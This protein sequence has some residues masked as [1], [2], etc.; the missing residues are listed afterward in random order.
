V[1]HRPDSI[2]PMSFV[3]YEES[4]PWAKAI[5]ERV[6]TRHVR[7]S[8][9]DKVVGIQHFEDEL[10]L[11]EKEIETIV[12]WVNAGAPQGDPKLMPPA[13]KWPEDATRAT[14]PLKYVPTPAD[15]AYNGVTAGDVAEADVQA[16]TKDIAYIGVVLNGDGVNPYAPHPFIKLQ[17]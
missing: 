8:D 10:S 12:Q 11:S 6:I 2:A 9:L 3:T 15:L 1:C 5:R 7:P 14:A 17:Q 4:R 16:I 13:K